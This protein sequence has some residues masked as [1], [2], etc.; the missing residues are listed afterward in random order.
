MAKKKSKSKKKDA[1]EIFEIEKDNKSK[2]KELYSKEKNEGPPKKSVIKKESKQLKTILIVIGVFTLIFLVILFL[3]YK[4]VHFTVEGVKYKM[5][6]EGNLIFYDTFFNVIYDNGHKLEY[7]IY[8]RKDP[9]KLIKDV[10]YVGENLTLTKN[11]V[12]NQE[13]NFGCEG[14]GII[15]VGNIINMYENMGIKVIS[16]ENASCVLTGQ[17]T[18]IIIKE[19]EETSVTKFGPSC[20]RIEINQ[21]E[22]LEGTER[23]IL[24]TFIELN[25]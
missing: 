18:Y 11:V 4:S 7:H 20:Y 17:Y 6:R 2:T 25:K 3:T 19:G 24:E 15:A 10:P 23:L 5:V 12:L 21:C 1:P 22:I 16:D 13:K 14:N 8:T 9:R